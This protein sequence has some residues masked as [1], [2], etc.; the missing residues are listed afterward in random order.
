[1]LSYDIFNY[2]TTARVLYH[3]G[4]NPYLVMP[5]EF[6]GD[7]NLLFTH[8][9]NKFALYGPSW[10]GITAVPYFLGLGNTVLE[11]IGFKF[12]NVLFYALSLFLILRNKNNP[13]IKFAKAETI[14]DILIRN[15]NYFSKF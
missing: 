1:M 7:Q 6:I 13:N 10:I 3:Y 12:L 5:I 4:E 11:I 2:L 8:A 14:K 9:A 15:I